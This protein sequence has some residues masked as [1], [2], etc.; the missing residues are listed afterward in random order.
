[1][2]LKIFEAATDKFSVNRKISE[3]FSRALVAVGFLLK[4]PN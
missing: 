3:N 4:I 2:I 1:M